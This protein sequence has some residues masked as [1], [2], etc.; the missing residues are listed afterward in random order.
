[1]G[2]PSGTSKLDP[3]KSWIDRR[4]GE[5]VWNAMV[6]Y[7][8]VQEQGY[9]GEVTLVRDYVRP[10]RVLRPSSRRTVRFETRP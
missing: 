1:M 4:L 3:Y 10:K 7:W 5:G 8:E 2:R 6:L 9:P